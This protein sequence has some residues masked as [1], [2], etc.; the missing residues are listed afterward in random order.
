MERIKDRTNLK[1]VLM[2]VIMKIDGW[3]MEEDLCEVYLK[4]EQN[5]I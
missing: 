1:H 2:G 5:I 3:W 4:C